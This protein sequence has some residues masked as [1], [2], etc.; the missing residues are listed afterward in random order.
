VQ[1]VEGL[2]TS[3]GP[4]FAI[5]GPCVIESADLVWQCAEVLGR[6]RD[7]LGVPVVFKASYLKDNRSRGDSFR[8]PGLEAGLEILSAVR[9]RTGLPVTTDVHTEEEAR[10]A[11]TVVD[12]LQIPAFLCRQSRLIEAAAATGRVV[13][14]KKGQFLPPEDARFIVEKARAAGAAAVAI[15]ER[16]TS[17]GYGDL[18][19]DPRSFAILRSIPVAA[20]FDATHSQQRPGGG[21]T[22]GDRRFL[23]PVTRAA[24]A[25]G[26]SGVFFETHPDPPHAKSDRATQLPLTEAEEFLREMAAFARAASAI[27]PA[28]AP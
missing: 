6:A 19:V 12:V 8:G 9:E 18:I 10:R 5:A 24:I 23:R 21:E 7:R 27:G 17:F 25:A 14:V 16:G 15:T 28:A 1:A 2:F 4:F 20:V 26:A 3:G 11:A 13:N 22:G